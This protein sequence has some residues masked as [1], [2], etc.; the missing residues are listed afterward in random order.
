MTSDP[1]ADLGEIK[2][3]LR[4]RLEELAEQLLGAPNRETRSRRTWRWGAKGSA[5]LEVAGPKRGLFYS[6]E[7]AVGGTALDLIVY[8][9]SCGFGEAVDYAR[10]F[11]GIADAAPLP[12]VNTFALIERA[13][14]RAAAEL[15]AEADER[16][17]VAYARATWGQSLPVAGTVAEHYLTESCGIRAPA[18]GWP[19]AFRFHPWTNALIVAA[20]ALDGSVQAIER[21]FLTADGRKAEA[22]PERPSKQ[23]NGV[24]HGAVV[25]LPGSADGPL[26]LAEGPETGLSVW[27]ATGAETWVCLGGFARV[28][29]PAGRAVIRCSDDDKTSKE[30]KTSE[31]KLVADL[32]RWEGCGADIRIAW[33]WP[34]RRRD[35]FDFN[36][37]MQ[38]AAPTWCASASPRQMMP[39]RSLPTNRPTTTR[40]RT[41][42][43]IPART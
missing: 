29:L 16:K 24:L 4:D 32:A 38:L 12:P 11:L 17:R 8:A 34:E 10:A 19:D 14:K 15:E 31:D 2:A 40:R 37:V 1:G 9:R 30:G 39:H 22:T 28:T 26:M 7:G 36:D 3:Q 20:T 13:Q 41:D 5:A 6:H 42:R 35:D 18:D 43:I 25:R 27:A 33:P 21:V 23:T